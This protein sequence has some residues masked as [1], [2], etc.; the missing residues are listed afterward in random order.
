MTSVARVQDILS[1]LVSF[2]TTSRDSNLPLIEWV[3]DFLRPLGA[4][5][6]RAPSPDGKK[7]NLWARFGPDKPG[8]IVLSGHTDVVPVD[9]QPWDTSPWELIERD[10]KWYGRGSCDMKGFLALALA[11]AET[12]SKMPL[13]KAV[14]FAFSYDE[15][16]GCAGVEPMI[17]EIV[18]RGAAPS[19]VWVGEPTLWGVL[20]AHKGIRDY[21]IKITGKAAHSSDPRLGASAIHE[22]IDLLGLLR[23]IAREQE[24]NA[25]ASSDFD[26][27]WTTITVGEIGGGTAANI[28]ARECRFVFDIRSVP[29]TDAG[30][31]LVPFFAEVD[32]VHARLSA[33]GSECGVQVSMFANAP[34]LRVDRD[35][36]AEQF[37]RAL[38]GD[39]NLRV[40]AFATEAGQF[41]KAGFPAVICGPGSIDQAH[42]PNEFVA[43]SE[44]EKGLA[45]FRRF[46]DTLRA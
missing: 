39:N 23:R 45:V 19:V 2:D 29:G 11:H 3:E 33:L 27:S 8:G 34:P 16:I 4:E 36:A 14:H 7:S 17:E 46:L 18:R 42:Q 41:Q 44:I 13:N 6:V 22:A 12:I 9:G 25:P 28:L 21:E 30:A 10:G 24:A 37:I 32:R 31:L 26:P 35:S 15:E 40:A 43:V 1:S 20:S 38:T 5:L